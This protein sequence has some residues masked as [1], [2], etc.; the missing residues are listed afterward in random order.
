MRRIL[1]HII[2]GRTI[3]NFL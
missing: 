3:I 2:D 1:V